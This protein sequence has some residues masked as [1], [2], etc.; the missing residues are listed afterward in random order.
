MLDLNPMKTS[1]TKKS[2]ATMNRNGRPASPMTQSMHKLNNFFGGTNSSNLSNLTKKDISIK[3]IEEDLMKNVVSFYA[4]YKDISLWD[5]IKSR[6][7]IFMH[8]NTTINEKFKEFILCLKSLIEFERYYISFGQLIPEWR[9]I[10]APAQSKGFSFYKAK[11]DIVDF[12]QKMKQHPYYLVAPNATVHGVD[13]QS[14]KLGVEMLDHIQRV[15]TELQH[16]LKVKQDIIKDYLNL[17]KS[18]DN[19]DNFFND[20]LMLGKLKENLNYLEHEIPSIN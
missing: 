16:Y 10:S 2:N 13:L 17:W 19:R 11:R 7:E 18:R 4:V 12:L 1:Q 20:F 5:P 3:I 8:K 9:S 15:M 6:G 14:K